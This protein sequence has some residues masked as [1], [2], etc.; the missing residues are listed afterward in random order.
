MVDDST[1]KSVLAPHL[2]ESGSLDKAFDEPESN[3]FDLGMDSISA[4]ALLDDLQDHGVTLEFTEL[5]ADPSVKF[6]R[7]ASERG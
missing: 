2:S 1:L 3:L 7:E 6:I 4:F 5:I